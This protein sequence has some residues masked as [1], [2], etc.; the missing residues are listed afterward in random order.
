MNNWFECKIKYE[1]NDE[2][3]GKPV[4][5]NEPYLVDALSFT[6]AEARMTEQ[7][8]TLVS[9]EF[10]ISSIKRVNFS[11][12]VDMA[13]GQY[14]YKCKVVFPIIDEKSAKE[15]KVA[16]TLL[17]NADSVQDAYARLEQNLNQGLSDY[18][19]KSIAETPIAD[20]F[21]YQAAAEGQD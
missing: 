6:E 11:E 1:K 8:K 20:I 3:S 7:A 17:I 4:K 14:W 2:G 19:I 12:V 15:K 9:G 13:S 10:S 5:K 21:P 18:E 16:N